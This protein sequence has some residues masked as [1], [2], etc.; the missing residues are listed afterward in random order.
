MNRVRVYRVQHAEEREEATEGQLRTE[1]FG[2]Q[3]LRHSMKIKQSSTSSPKNNNTNLQ[4]RKL[5][6][7][8]TYEI[9]PHV[10]AQENAQQELIHRSELTDELVH[11]Q[12][13]TD[14]E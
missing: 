10:D 14:F 11:A 13:E 6:T 9:T 12:S 7:E 3:R 2:V 1:R 8:F 5:E 4:N